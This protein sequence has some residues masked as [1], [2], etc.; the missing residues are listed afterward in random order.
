M[1]TPMV[2]QMIKSLEWQT[3]NSMYTT[4]R[5]IELLAEL[6]ALKQVKNINY[7]TVLPTAIC[8][9]ANCSEIVH[10]EGSAYCEFHASL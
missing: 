5:N 8:C 4:Q 10:K 3:K 9:N 7:D 2:D 1:E 6:K